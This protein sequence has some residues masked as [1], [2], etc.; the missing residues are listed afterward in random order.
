[1]P[2]VRRCWGKKVHVLRLAHVRH[3]GHDAAVAECFD[4]KTRFFTPVSEKEEVP[5]VVE[6]E[7]TAEEEEAEI[8]ED[9]DYDEDY[10]DDDDDG[11]EG[12]G[13]HILI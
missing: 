11:K 4:A 2:D 12:K 8:D 10:E 9:D 5:S 7:E 13:L 3:K 1:M 6:A